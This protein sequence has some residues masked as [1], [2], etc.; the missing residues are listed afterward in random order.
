VRNSKKKLTGFTM[1]ELLTALA[2][3]AITV[4]VA[5][6]SFNATINNNRRTTAVNDLFATMQTARSESITRNAQ[7]T[8]CPS[9]SGENCD[10]VNWHEGWIYFADLDRNR[11][12][13]GAE[14]VIGVIDERPQLTIQSAEFGNFLAYRPN[15]RVM[16]G[17]VAENTGSL[18]ICDKRGA[19]HARVL[20]IDPS[21]QPQ[22]S[23]LMPGGA[24]PACPS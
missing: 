17:T 15:G 20:S 22:V 2:V 19:A 18:V 21:G 12:V 6:P 16:V 4:S 14:T 11:A 10:G 5:I 1:P 9:V 13:N 8:I 24:A 23:D 3:G 7:I